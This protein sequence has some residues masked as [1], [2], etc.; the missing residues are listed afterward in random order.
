MFSDVVFNYIVVFIALEVYEVQ[1]QKATTIIG[2]LARMYEHYQKSIFIFLVMHPTFYFAMALM[3]MSDYN[4]YAITL[5][6]IKAV[7]IA[8]KIV[9]I[10]KVFIDRDLSEELTL[11]LLAPLNR[12][13]PYI[14]V[15][16]YPVLIYLVLTPL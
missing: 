2:M 8:T 6:S 5:F 9:L 15:V 7:D 14:G 3:V 4:V 11:A 13:Y 12:F 10:K 1:W 16:L